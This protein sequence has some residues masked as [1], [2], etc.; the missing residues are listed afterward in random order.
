MS[1]QE[2]VILWV[3]HAAEAYI[4]EV[5][6]RGTLR[7]SRAMHDYVECILQ[8]SDSRLVVDLTG[9][10]YLDS[11]FLGCLVQIHRHHS[12]PQHR[13]AIAAPPEKVKAL[14]AQLHLDRLFHLVPAAPAKA[15]EPAAL[16]AVAVDPCELGRH[17]MEC[18]RR[19]AELG[20]P[21]KDAFARIADHLAHDLDQA[22]G[23]PTPAPGDGT[24][25]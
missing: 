24:L 7:E 8:E 13:V 22:R 23:K 2:P 1:C 5:R 15:C 12:G 4:V 25:S 18:H 10:D 21:Q 6:G 3:A 20:G 14:L 16:P 11:T 9:C 19:L 17:V